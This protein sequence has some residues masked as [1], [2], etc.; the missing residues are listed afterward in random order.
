M[1]YPSDLDAGFRAGTAMAAVMMQ[2][3]GF[4]AEFAA[5]KAELR[6]ALGL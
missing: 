4:Q 2:Q 3:P 6:A 5:A 1:H